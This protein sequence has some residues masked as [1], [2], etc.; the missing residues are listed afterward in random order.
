MLGRLRSRNGRRLL[1]VAAALAVFLAALAPSAM[2]DGVP[3]PSLGP[4]NFAPAMPE[5]FA[6][7]QNSWA[8]SMQW[9]NNK[10]Y[11]GTNRAY[12]CVSD[13]ELHVSLPQTYPYPPFD[14][15]M[16]C[17]ANPANLP[18]RAEIWSWTPQT[19]AWQRVY[20]APDNIPNPD[21]PGKYVPPDVGYRT[22]AVYT[23][24]NGQSML[25][26]GGVNTGPMWNGT[27]PPP[28]I[29]Y[30]TDG[31]NFQS[32][33][34]DPGTFMDS[35]TQASFRGMTT[36]NGQLFA[37]NGN[38]EGEGP[39]I[40]SS[41]PTAGNNAW[42]Q[43]S[44]GNMQFYDLAVFNG[45]LYAGLY[46]LTSGYS[47]VRTQATGPAPY[48][49][50]TV[51]PPGAYLTTDVPPSVVSMHVFNNQLYVGTGF[52]SE[53]I[54][55]NADDTWQLLV[56]Q[57]RQ[58]PN[59]STMYPLSGLGAGWNNGFNDH[60]WRMQDSNGTMYV[61]TYDSSTTWKNIPIVANRIKQLMG[62]DL[63]STTN[64]WYYDPI[65]TT[66]FGNR[67]DFGVRNW[68]NTPFGL[69]LGTADDYY[70][71]NILR[72]LPTNLE[73]PLI[74]PVSP[75][76]LN[77]EMDNQQP[78]LSW[79]PVQ[80]AV[81]YIVLRAPIKNILL[82]AT[83]PPGHN[84]YGDQATPTPTTTAVASPATASNLSGQ[85]FGA[86]GP[87]TNVT[88]PG[89]YEQIGTTP[90]TL[91]VDAPITNSKTEYL[92]EVVAVNVEGQQS[93]VSN[94]VLGPS[95]SPPQTVASA[96]AYADWLNQRGRFVSAQAYTTTQ[97]AL[98]QVGTL[99]NSGNLASADDQL[100][101]LDNQDLA[102][103]LVLAPDSTDFD[104][105][106]TQLERRLKL[107]NAGLVNTTSLNQ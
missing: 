92:Y 101:S 58:T 72:G 2:A 21:Y 56:G 105:I 80:G 5:G 31:S 45:W 37:I 65:T 55:I 104:V 60:V 90:D 61:G 53:L 25:F 30:T 23:G 7:R 74:W 1:A 19:N 18:L 82:P 34:Q 47:V 26:V 79:N 93:N 42:Q 100:K 64:G 96:T 57:P 10:L 99:I 73:N 3:S 78:V 49:W 36:Y 76:G 91:F 12:R 48:Q 15:D 84:P 75:T 29:L 13:W 77:L 14:P 106:L 11:V 32:V 85:R 35:L 88:F 98:Q 50:Q 4:Q 51:V 22:M 28:R 95:L 16:A 70:G 86:T 17:T 67:F 27:V 40:A 62:F 66:G 43:V 94:L 39:L 83:P 103:S 9:W 63:Y 52:P 6:D 97:Q 69:F 46:N 89:V 81:S 8:W 24:T 20:Q 68:A 87:P 71:L 38:A 102:G 41:N 54:R 107:A 33:P 44:P 59:G